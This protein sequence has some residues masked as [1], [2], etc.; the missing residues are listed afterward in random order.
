MQLD[1]FPLPSI[2]LWGLAV[3]VLGLSPHVLLRRSAESNSCEIYQL[4]AAAVIKRGSTVCYA[5][6]WILPFRHLITN[7]ESSGP[8]ISD[9]ESQN[10]L[11]HNCLMYLLSF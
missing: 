11:Q 6:Q 4:I 3:T 2:P 5:V 8:R 10:G 7:H 9:A 1:H